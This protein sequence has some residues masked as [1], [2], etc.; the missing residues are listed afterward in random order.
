L[1]FIGKEVKDVFSL[2]M[3]MQTTQHSVA[4]N[5]LQANYGLNTPFLEYEKVLRKLTHTYEYS[6]I[7]STKSLSFFTTIFNARLTNF[8][9]LLPKSHDC[10]C[11]VSRPILATPPL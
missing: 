4:G 10:S 5:M 2:Q 7:T 1:A 3:S 11:Y 9:A 6:K 8:T